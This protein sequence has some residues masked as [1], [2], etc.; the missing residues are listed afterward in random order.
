MHHE[1]RPVTV[2]TRRLTIR[3]SVAAI[4]ERYSCTRM[5]CIAGLRPHLCPLWVISR[6]SVIADAKSASPSKADIADTSNTVV[7]ATSKCLARCNKSYMGDKAT[8]K[9]SGQ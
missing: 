7:A 6:P 8:K 9:Q 2:H 5:H 1:T 3:E 4:A